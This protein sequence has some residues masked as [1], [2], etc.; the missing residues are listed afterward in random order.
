MI[1]YLR[2][3]LLGTLKNL[4]WVCLV[5]KKSHLNMIHVLECFQSPV[6]LA[7]FVGL[8]LQALPNHVDLSV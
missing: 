8:G 6:F 4:S 3:K 7:C 2:Q 5:L 1:L